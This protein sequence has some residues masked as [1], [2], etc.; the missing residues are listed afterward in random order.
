MLAEKEK[1]VAA[2]QVKADVLSSNKI[3]PKTQI[4]NIKKHNLYRSKWIER[5][6]GVMD[7]VNNI[8]D[9]MEKKPSVIIA[10]LGIET[11]EDVN[12]VIPSALTVPK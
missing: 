4:T 10:D 5:K 11:D 9:G 12:A 6:N 8:A 2:M 1:E 7:I 3:D